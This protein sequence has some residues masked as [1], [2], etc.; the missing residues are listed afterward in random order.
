MQGANRLAEATGP[1]VR[2]LSIVILN[3]NRPDLISPLLHCLVKAKPAFA[4]AG[5]D[6]QIIVGDTGSTDPE[7]LAV[8]DGLA[9][10][11]EVVRGLRY[12]FSA[13]NNQLAFERARCDA[14]L[15]LNNDVILPIDEN[16]L[17]QMR[18]SFDADA[19]LGIVGAYLHFP[20]ESLQHAGV[21]FAPT[22]ERAGLPFHF[23]AGERA[24]ISALRTR[25]TAAVTG[26]CLMIRAE[27]FKRLGGFDQNY[28]A[29]AQDIDLCL[30]AHRLGSHISIMQLGKLVHLENA[31]RPK[32]EAHAGDRELF[33]QRWRSYI[34][35][36][37]L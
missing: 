28:A 12:Q 2:G 35:A 5:F 29:E 37:E 20:D 6:L 31:T 3:L 7:T 34:Q 15:F 33:L 26:A 9:S 4:H 16:P 19:K 22:G 27:L 21:A 13:N 1:K 30:A 11:A 36:F 25:S 17:M 8:Y 24:P 18:A 23:M 10:E 32:G 14:I